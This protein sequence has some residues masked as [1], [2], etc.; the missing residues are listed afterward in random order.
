GNSAQGISDMSLIGIVK[1]R[2]FREMVLDQRDNITEQ[3]HSS[4]ESSAGISDTGSSE[5]IIALLKQ[6]NE[7]L[8]RIESKT[9]Q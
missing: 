5:E 8:K 6:M 7:T 4:S 1:A 2:E 3:K 9:G